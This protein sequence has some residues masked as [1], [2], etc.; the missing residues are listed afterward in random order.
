MPRDVALRN[1][2]VM[3]INGNR[4]WIYADAV[5]GKSGRG[6][7]TR[8]YS[9]ILPQMTCAGMK[10][11]FTAKAQRAQRDGAGYRSQ[12]AGDRKTHILRLLP[13]TC[14]LLPVTCH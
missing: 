2:G 11:L 6:M 14:Y 7:S 13:V 4:K 1:Q 3:S 8:F 9:G 12:D 5:E 10:G